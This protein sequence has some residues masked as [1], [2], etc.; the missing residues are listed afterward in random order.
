MQ[1]LME[2]L[3]ASRCQGKGNDLSQQ[4]W[5]T[6]GTHRGHGLNGVSQERF[7]VLIPVPGNV[8]LGNRV[9]AGD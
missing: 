8:K 2:H 7:E 1:S 9:F 6:T 5:S 3:L 4:T